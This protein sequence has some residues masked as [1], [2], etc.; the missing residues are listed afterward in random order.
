VADIAAAID[1]LFEK[2]SHIACSTPFQMGSR[3]VGDRWKGVQ[4][5]SFFSV[6]MNS[7][8]RHRHLKKQMGHDA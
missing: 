4:V 3:E 8:R 7:R 6:K 5:L 2:G 1:N